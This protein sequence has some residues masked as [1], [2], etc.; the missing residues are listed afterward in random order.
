MRRFR[1]LYGA[2][3]VNLLVLVLSFV[4]A[5]FA[6][7]GWF[8]RPHDVETVIEWFVAA[9]LLHDL[10]AVPLYTLL[11]RVAFG[12]LG[13]RAGGGA[14][15]RTVLGLINSTPYVRIPAILSGLLLIV[16]FPVIFGLG[17]QSE[18][19]ASGIAESGYLARWL[20]ASGVMFALSAVVW[21][22]AVGRAGVGAGAGSGDPEGSDRVGAPE[23]AAV[24]AEHEKPGDDVAARPGETATGDEVSRPP[25]SD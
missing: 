24:A 8:Q 25:V 11:D 10:V 21:G 23:A 14:G 19:D 16:F 2:G 7:Q 22:V 5:G 3:P 15:P 6:V 13:R 9:I 4:I 20:I 18:L 1:V 17:S 12:W